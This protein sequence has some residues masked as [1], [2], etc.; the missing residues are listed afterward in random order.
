M[1]YWSNEG[2]DVGIENAKQL[3][4]KLAS[5]KPDDQLSRDDISDLMF[6]LRQYEIELNTIK[7]KRQREA[8]RKAK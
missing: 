4:P 6:I 2:I 8:E 3:L 7:F 5:Y 1:R